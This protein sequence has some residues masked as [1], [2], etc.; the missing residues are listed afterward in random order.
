MVVKASTMMET[1]VVMDVEMTLMTD[2]EAESMIDGRNTQTA[3]GAEVRLR[4]DV[5]ESHRDIAVGR[6]SVEEVE[7]V[8]ATDVEVAAENIE[9]DLPTDVI[10]DLVNH[11][12]RGSNR[13]RPLEE[14]TCQAK[15]VLPLISF[16]SYILLL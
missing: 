1:D 13:S 7:V 14:W 16:L 6:G 9:V 2:R 4:Q 3:V 11:Q 10:L 12:T 8:R 15:V 5:A